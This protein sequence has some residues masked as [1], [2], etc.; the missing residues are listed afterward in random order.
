MKNLSEWM[1]T[2]I[3]EENNKILLNSDWLEFDRF[4]WEGLLSRVIS[5]LLNEGTF[6]LCTDE[7]YD[8]FARYISINLNR[9]GE[10]RPLIPVFLLKEILPNIAQFNASQNINVIHDM[11]SLGFRKYAFWYVGNTNNP[12]GQLALSKPQDSFFWIFDESIQSALR[13]DSKDSMIDY[14]LIQMYKIF[15]KALFGVIFGDIVI[16]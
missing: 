10:N 7:K 11:L 8:W 9:I 2:T 12:M 15:E 3:R 13:L 16:E 4:E 5:F 14:K 1:L 6:L